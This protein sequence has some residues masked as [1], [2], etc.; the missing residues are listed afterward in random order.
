MN[1]SDNR[2]EEIKHKQHTHGELL[3]DNLDDIQFL[4]ATIER[5]RNHK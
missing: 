3:I 4:I 1:P 2:V 5:L